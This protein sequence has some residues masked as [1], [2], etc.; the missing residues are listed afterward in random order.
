MYIFYVFIAIEM[1]GT[2][3]TAHESIAILAK[4]PI[5]TRAT[6]IDLYEP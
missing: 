6:L 1:T 4:G 5:I 3:A 2:T